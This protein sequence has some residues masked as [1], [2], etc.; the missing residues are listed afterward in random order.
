MVDIISI[1]DEIDSFSV[2]DS[3]LLD[4]E[5]YSKTCRGTTSLKIMTQNIRSINANLDSFCLLLKRTK[6]DIDILVLTEC[7]LDAIKP[8]PQIRG[9]NSFATSNLLNQ[10][11]GIV[12]YVR[13]NITC[14]VDEPVCDETNCLTV[15]IKEDTA[16][17]AIY[18]SPSF[19]NTDKFLSSIDVVLT[20]MKS[21]TNIFFIG[22]VN[23][24][25][26]PNNLDRSSNSYLNLM[27]EHGLLPAHTYP[28]REDNCLDHIN[29][30]SQFRAQTYVL[31]TQVTD[32]RPVT[33]S[34]D[35]IKQNENT[36]VNTLRNKIN[37][38]K[39]ISFLETSDL[40][41]ILSFNDPN[42]AADLLVNKITRA[43]V[44]NTSTLHIPRRYRVFKPWMTTGLLKCTKT[45]DKLHAKTKQQPG[46]QIVSLTYRRYRNFCNSLLKKLKTSYEKIELEKAANNPKKTW[47][48]IKDITHLKQYKKPPTE[49][50]KSNATDEINA[51]NEVNA[52]FSDIG[53]SLAKQIL[54]NHDITRD[55]GIPKHIHTRSFVLLDT[56]DNEVHKVINNLK[57]DSAAG[58]DGIAI[59]FIK[60][61]KHIIIPYLT[62]IF[63]MCFKNGVFPDLFKK[64]LIHPI[65]KGGNR[66][67]VGNYR[68]ISVLPALSKILE[69]LMNSR[70]TNYLEKENL[71]SNSQFG[72]RAGRST[73]DAV[74]SLTEYIVDLLDNKRK[75][76]GIFLDLAKAFDTV[77]IPI[78]LSKMENIGIRGQSLEIFSDYLTNRT[79]RVK[80]GNLTSSDLP[81]TFGV[82]QGS[83]LG[84]SLFLI[85]INELCLH[86]PVN[87]RIFSFADD[88][89]LVYEGETWMEARNNAETGLQKVMIWLQNNLLSL[90]LTKTKY[91]SFSIRSPN[92]HEMSIKAHSCNFPNTSTC[93]CTQ[94]A[95]VSSIKY[96]GVILDD[97]LSWSY[98]LDYVT[99]RT[100]K[101]IY[102]F[103]K[104]RHIASPKL[105]KTLYLA[106]GQSILSYC[107]SVWGGACKTKIL[108]LERAQRSLLK[109]LYLKPYRFPTFSLLSETEVLS[110]RQLFIEKIILIYHRKIPFDPNIYKNKRRND[111][112]CKPPKVRTDFA[113][114]HSKFIAP[115]LYK[116]IN[117]ILKLY[118]KTTHQCKIDIRNWLMTYDY[119][120]TE[121]LLVITV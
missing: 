18:R 57:S 116:K 72:F 100:R 118:T 84:P 11:D 105:K 90:N 53:Q 1:Q 111:L 51:I 81:V 85:Y 40:E 68:P 74:S 75:C 9:Y 29:L 38:P 28:T 56:D 62:H 76:I 95:K 44:E 36:S 24:D 82:P 45:R 8:I 89:A 25:I 13:D 80:I 94:L 113:R 4:P 33:I 7:W 77:S 55:S 60:M 42:K 46:N 63:N 16:I 79:Q 12:I 104:L 66:D 114:R 17:V 48:I 41:P 14:T 73:E 112:I 26:K 101:L 10:N 47:N 30:K 49:L 103:K 87:G 107:I 59:K 119:A 115:Y 106:M 37:Y 88:T 61:T 78:L 5:E 110:I 58:L 93:N 23:I 6:V 20:S 2:S 54:Q 39:A 65:H 102:L 83:V 22:D 64:S 71:I 92:L 3:F 43:L 19:S 67:V 69:K 99:T 120:N 27:A 15:K 50:L 98:H 121:S 21:F 35:C 108:K 70:L 96:L 52:Y 32:H 34:L 31:K 117:R 86:T 97:R 109:V 91:M